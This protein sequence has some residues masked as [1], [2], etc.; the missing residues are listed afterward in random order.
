MIKGYVK[1]VNRLSKIL[2]NI[3]MVIVF[4]TAMLIIAN[5]ILRRVVNM[6]IVGTHDLVLFFT[7]A[8]I[9][10]SLAYC[11]VKDGHIYI[12]ILVEKFPSKVQK[13]IDIV[14]GTISSM[15]LMF[16]SWHMFLYADSMRK[17]KEVSLT[18]HIPH[19]PFVLILAT[20]FGVLGLVVIGKVLLI[21]TKEGDK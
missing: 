5:V 9:A 15:F 17:T 19:Y 11:A 4:F 3:A 1:F 10:L 18:I 2:E 20:G 13:I 14:I 12:S 7:S 6:P 8:A 16:V 21:F